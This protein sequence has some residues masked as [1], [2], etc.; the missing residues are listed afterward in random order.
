MRYEQMTSDDILSDQFGLE[1][2][3]AEIGTRGDKWWRPDAIR[4]QHPLLDDAGD[5]AD[6]DDDDWI[7]PDR[8]EFGAEP[9]DEEEPE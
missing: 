8:Q 3:L 9:D 6:D 7:F 5:E 4:A 1:T 2:A